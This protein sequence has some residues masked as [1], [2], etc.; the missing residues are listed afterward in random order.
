MISTIIIA[1]T[2]VACPFIYDDKIPQTNIFD[3]YEHINTLFHIYFHASNY[4]EIFQIPV[5]HE[6]KQMPHIKKGK[7]FIISV[8]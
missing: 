3:L 7:S 5:N 8:A 2:K 6:M 4:R 1:I